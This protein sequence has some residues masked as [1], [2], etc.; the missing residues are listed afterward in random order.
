MLGDGMLWLAEAMTELADALDAGVGD[1]DYATAVTARLTELV[2]PLEA[3]ILLADE[4]GSLT[5]GAAG[6]QRAARL[7]AAETRLA[8]GPCT[9]GFADGGELRRGFLP[10][11][12]ARWPRYCLAATDAGY[13]TVTVL[14]VRRQD[15]VLGA[16]VFLGAEGEQIG[17]DEYA[18]AAVLVRL[19][20][21]GILDRRALN[22]GAE[23]A[24]QLQRALD[25]RVLIEQAKGALAARL[26]VSPSAA[27]ELLRGF[28]RR[29]RILL[30]D[31]AGQVVDGV[32]TDDDLR[33]GKNSKAAQH[34]G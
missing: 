9:S 27:F 1:A 16:V 33:A 17:D 24:D 19:A 31:V 13:R 20:A 12:T 21:I 32:L 22:A 30:A 10:A 29:N 8:E 34:S 26:G 7:L 6:S 11:L 4:S 25:S 14:P 15:A 5:I 3:G 2:G 28:A 18:L 23:K